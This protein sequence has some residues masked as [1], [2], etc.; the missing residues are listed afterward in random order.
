MR[1]GCQSQQR[2]YRGEPARHPSHSHA[3]VGFQLIVSRDPVR[4]VR[5]VVAVRMLSGLQEIDTTH[6]R[7]TATTVGLL[8]VRQVN[9]PTALGQSYEKLINRQIGKDR[10]I[11]R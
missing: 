2:P 1:I 9:S 4:K 7:R 5:L 8:I 10:D 6:A 3:I 11:L